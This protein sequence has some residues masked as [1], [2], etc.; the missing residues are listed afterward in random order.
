MFY[1]FGEIFN[2]AFS[3]IYTKVFWGTDKR[4]IRIP[5][6]ARNK[7]NIIIGKGFSCGYACRITAG[8]NEEHPVTIGNNVSLGDYCQIEGSGG[9]TIGD[10][11][12]MASKVFITSN[13]HGCYSNKGEA[14]QASPECPP[15]D[16]PV[17]ERSVRIGNNAWIGNGVSILMGV[18]IGKGAIIG[19]GSVV[20]K[21][22]P[23]NC[24]AVGVPAE[25]IKVYNFEKESW[26]TI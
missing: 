12:L 10:N 9:V 3:V 8:D 22:I 1:S 11:V 17:I 23:E 21:D 6:R 19:A 14:P 16:R 13:S 24:I 15:A 7:K 20:T 5:F 26:D 18:S 2:N 4:I 25:V